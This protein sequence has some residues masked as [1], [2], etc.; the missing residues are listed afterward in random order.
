MA[1][2]TMKR[3]KKGG[4]LQSLFGIKPTRASDAE[5]F[6]GSNGVL[7]SKSKTDR[8]PLFSKDGGKTWDYLFDMI[9]YQKTQPKDVDA[10][11]AYKEQ[12]SIKEKSQNAIYSE[13]TA[14]YRRQQEAD[15]ARIKSDRDAWARSSAKQYGL[16]ETATYEEVKA[17]ENRI[18][19]QKASSGK[20]AVLSPQPSEM[21]AFS[22]LLGGKKRKT[23]KYNRRV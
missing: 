23:R 10:N 15:M 12:E 7:I 9:D 22:S 8:R 21:S 11:I 6:K 17:A 19:P 18:F 3:S 13:S 4:G 2:K 16:P 1:R 5:I 20:Y 14:S